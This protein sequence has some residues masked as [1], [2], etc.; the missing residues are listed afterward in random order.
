M[1][2][3]NH[4]GF[5]AETWHVFVV[6]IICVWLSAALVCLANAAMPHLNKAGIFLYVVV[7]FSFC[8]HHHH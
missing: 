4:P 1:Y 7:F 5:V 2:A 8:C 6:Y 3:L